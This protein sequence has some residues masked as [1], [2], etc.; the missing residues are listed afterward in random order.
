M[1]EKTIPFGTAHTYIAPPFHEQLA[2]AENPN[3]QQG[4]QT[5]AAIHP[6]IEGVHEHCFTCMLH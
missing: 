2:S 5:F 6:L 1:T 3:I 4:L